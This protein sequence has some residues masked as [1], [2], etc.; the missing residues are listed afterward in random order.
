MIF[1]GPAGSEANS[2]R[3][4]LQLLQGNAP[5]FGKL[6]LTGSAAALQKTPGV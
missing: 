1:K 4:D 2:P 5:H 3:I 6:L